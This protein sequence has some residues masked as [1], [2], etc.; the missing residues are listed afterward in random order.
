MRFAVRNPIVN[1]RQACRR[2]F[3]KIMNTRLFWKLF[4]FA[5]PSFMVGLDLLII[6]VAI[7]PMARTLH[8][9][10]ATMQWFIT[11]YA[12]GTSSFYVPAGK[13]CDLYGR[14]KV[15]LAG[16][17][18]FT[19]SSILVASATT[20]W[21]VIIGRLLQGFGGAIEIT[22]AFSLI[23]RTFAPR[24]R[25]LPMGMM[26]S[27]T[28]LGMALGP[29]IGGFLIHYFSWRFAFWINVPVGILA[30]FVVSKV[31]HEVETLTQQRRID[32]PG[33][34]FV[35]ATLIFF[36]IWLTDAR[37]D[38]WGSIVSLSFLFAFVLSLIILLLIERSREDSLLDLP[39][40]KV[41]NFFGGS[42]A[43]FFAYFCLISSIFLFG[44]FLQR[45][46]GL[47]PLQAGVRLIPFSL[48]F[49]I[50]A[51]IGTRLVKP[52]GAKKV[53]L[54]GY[55]ILL[56]STIL[57]TFVTPT[58]SYWLFALASAL[59]ALG[60]VWINSASYPASV[61]FMPQIKAGASSGHA[62]MVRWVGGA[63]GTAIIATILQQAT[64]HYFLHH[65]I[66]INGY[67]NLQTDLIAM[68]QGQMSLNDFSNNHNEYFQ[69][70]AHIVRV[71]YGYGFVISMWCLAGAA[72]IGYLLSLFFLRN[73]TPAHEE[74]NEH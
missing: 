23:I 20:A 11:A 27:S 63:V 2:N 16:I 52:L 28:G 68:L 57:F 60:F 67:P 74:A 24:E 71:A 8:V 65:L 7:E 14:K 51:M 13:L 45:V 48:I 12:I 4:A 49:F 5:L 26:V 37:I 35:L 29:V 50:G 6:G 73:D 31:L 33:L 46:V 56:F 42:M 21:L 47:N 43:G 36:T 34:I 9:S 41:T 62:G 44:I 72:L 3:K 32:C 54:I 38:G 17:I 1:R 64:Q 70:I 15:F 25:T 18:L 66:H 53:I 39:L 58:S 59:L 19:L 30:I 55:L 40:F 69:S 22:G 10:I 61:E